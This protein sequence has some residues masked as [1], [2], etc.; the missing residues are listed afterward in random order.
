M[1]RP[2]LLKLVV[3][4]CFI[5]GVITF[6]SGF[7]FEPPGWGPLSA[8]PALAASVILMTMAGAISR[9]SKM[10]G[11]LCAITLVL[12]TIRLPFGYLGLVARKGHELPG[13]ILIY[14]TFASLNILTAIFLLGPPY[15]R[16]REQA[17]ESTAPISS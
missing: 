9:L 16:I 8:F 7:L 4:W 12:L 2:R 3:R 11:R 14:S 10:A 15:R 5:S 1:K 6:V 13:V 17:H